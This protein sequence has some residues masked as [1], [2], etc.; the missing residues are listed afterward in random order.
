MD[1]GRGRSSERIGDFGTT[2]E[3]DLSWSAGSAGEGL[4]HDGGIIQVGQTRIWPPE[5]LGSFR[6]ELDDLGVL[7]KGVMVITLCVGDGWIRVSKRV[8]RLV[9]TEGS[10]CQDRKRWYTAEERRISTAR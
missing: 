1:A 5:R 9:G 3:V 7:L 2:G 10:P 6:G 8:C 4:V